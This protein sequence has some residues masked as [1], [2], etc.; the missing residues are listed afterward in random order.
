LKDYDV[1][2][3]LFFSYS[4]CVKRILILFVQNAFL[5]ILEV[6]ESPTLFLQ[7]ENINPAIY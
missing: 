2:P 4:L 3:L 6:N 1:K 7:R 5:E